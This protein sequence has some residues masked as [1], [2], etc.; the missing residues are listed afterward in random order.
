MCFTGNIVVD[1][2]LIAYDALFILV[3]RFRKTVLK[4]EHYFACLSVNLHGITR[5]H[6]TGIREILY[7]GVLVKSVESSSLVKIGEK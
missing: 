5:H 6:C 7:Q 2:R 4:C 1:Q 3:R